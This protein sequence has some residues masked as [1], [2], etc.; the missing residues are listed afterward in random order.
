TILRLSVGPNLGAQT[1]AAQAFEVAS[2]KP[3]N[4]NPDPSNPLS[5]IALMLPQPG[6]RF[7]AT[8]TPLRMLIMVAYELKQDAQLAGG[9]PDLLT[10]KYDITAR[11]A[12]SGALAMKELPQLL[13]SLLADRFKLKTHTEARELPLYDLVLARSDG[14]LGPDMKPS[15]S[16][17]SNADQVA[18]EQ[19]AA[20]AKGDVAS[21]VGKP[22]PCS[23]STDA[24]GGPLN[25]MMRGD[26]QE[27]KQVVEI[28][29]QFTGRAV[30]DKTGL[31]GR[32]DFAMKM[33]LQMVL[34]L[35]QRMG[36]SI[37]SAA[38]ANIPQSDGSSLMTAL[39]EQLGLKLESVRA[40]VDVVVI[41]SVEAPAPD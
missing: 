8:N 21:F 32:Y 18:A 29:T 3:S 34:A 4:P 31:T 22:R 28:L 30:R 26:G 27:M 41:D 9:P 39:S 24:S 17:C 1:P 5:M 20:L 33:D 36:A 12:G 13:R 7:T 37:P 14:R 25:L 10:A 6:G 38:A 15:T 11:A 19:G 35:A 2:V 40:P 23:V 16:D